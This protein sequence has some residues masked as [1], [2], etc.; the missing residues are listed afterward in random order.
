LSTS[1]ACS[2][3]PGNKR[4]PPAVPKGELNRSA[5]DRDSSVAVRAERPTS[6]ILFL[7]KPGGSRPGSSAW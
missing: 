6:T 3:T 2:S 7:K 5:C 1:V 4:S